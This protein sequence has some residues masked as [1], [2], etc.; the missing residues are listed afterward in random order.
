M[1]VRASARPRRGRS[2]QGR[3]MRQGRSRGPRRSP[4]QPIADGAFVDAEQPASRVADDHDLLGAHELLADDQRPDHV[5]G[6][7]ATRVA[8]DV[9]VA[10]PQSEGLPHVEPGIHAC[11]DGQLG[12]RGRRQSGPVE[13]LRVALVLGQH[14]GELVKLGH[15]RQSVGPNSR[16]SQRSSGGTEVG[17]PRRTAAEPGASGGRDGAPGARLNEISC[18]PPRP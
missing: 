9:R 14:P 8:D 13:R 3:R 4:R 11:H 16:L 15:R 6:G 1:G 17:A 12:Q 2:P 5:I 10:G 18:E 7:E